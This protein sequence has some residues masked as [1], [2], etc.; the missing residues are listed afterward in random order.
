MS[1]I[2]KTYLTPSIPREIFI[3]MAKYLERHCNIMVDLQFEL[4]SSGPKKGTKLEED[5][6]F[7][8]SPPLYWLYDEYKDD[9]EL[10]PVAP[11]FDD[12]RNKD[13][14]VYFSDVLVKNNRS[15]NSLDDIIGKTWSY[16]DTESLSGYFCIKK[17][18]RHLNLVCSGSHLNS[19]DY[20]RDNKA[21]VTCIDSNALLFVN[22]DFKKIHTFGPHPIQ[23]CIIKKSCK[24]K[25]EIIDAF[26]KINDDKE[27]INEFN[28]YKILR[29]GTVNENFFFKKYSIKHLV[30]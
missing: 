22:H 1:I 16:N 4:T 28:K 3:I 23:P 14:P 5:L 21:D 9:I 12:I 17:Y 8:C 18:M 30:N 13:E 26:K 29:F 19:L 7:M 25:N 11:I 27:V 24:Y 15:I 6:S 2:F 20:I 10:I